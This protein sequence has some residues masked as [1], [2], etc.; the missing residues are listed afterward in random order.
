MYKI[1]PH[2][3]ATNYGGILQAFALQQAL[4]Q[5]GVESKVV[6]FFSKTWQSWLSS[7]NLRATCGSIR[8]LL[9]IIFL[10]T[11]RSFPN[12]FYPYLFK[13]F[14]KKFMQ[15]WELDILRRNLSDLAVEEHPFVVGSDQVWRCAYTRKMESVPFFFLNFATKKQRQQ[16]IAYAASFGSDEWEGTPEETEECAR[17]LKDFK[18][19]SVREHSGIEICRE[20][21]GV[22]AVQMPDPT[23]LLEQ[24]DY[25]HLIRNWRTK[26]TDTPFM[27]VYLLDETEEK[28]TLTHTLSKEIGLY[29]QHLMPH[30]GAEKLM[31]RLPLSVPQWLRFIRDSVCVLTD[32]FHGCVFSIIFN[33]PFI[34]LGNENRGSARFDSLLG[35][36]GLRDRLVTNYDKDAILQLLNTPIDWER[37]HTIRHSE[38]KRALQFLQENLT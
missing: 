38:Q 29:A 20:V 10:G 28:R 34:C 32:S 1:L 4:K 13:R 14:K 36:F 23:L 25:N 19:V 11:P 21:F 18:A 17:L 7:F 9:Q 12:L 5:H 27:A 31:D 35:T 37:V 3:L 15:L 6:N 16:S 8:Y 24:E 2:P 22:E 30:P 33:K 26:S